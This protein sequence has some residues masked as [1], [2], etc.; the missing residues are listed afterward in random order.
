[1]ATV[2]ERLTAVESELARLRIQVEQKG[3]WIARI[4][5]SMKDFPEF[6]EV[7]QLGRD[8]RRSDLAADGEDGD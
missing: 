5:G 7:V 4:S 8:W 1:M 2:E 3:N 6:E